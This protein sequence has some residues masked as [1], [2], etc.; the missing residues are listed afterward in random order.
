[1]TDDLP[2]WDSD[3]LECWQPNASQR[4][5]AKE[6]WHQYATRSP[7]FATLYLAYCDDVLHERSLPQTLLAFLEHATATMIGAQGE[8]RTIKR[9]AGDVKAVRSDALEEAQ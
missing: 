5:R 3:P 6:L 1:M 4:A 2:D 8:D 7:D 9:L